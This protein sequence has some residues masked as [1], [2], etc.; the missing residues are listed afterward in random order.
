MGNSFSLMA[1]LTPPPP[2]PDDTALRPLR[3]HIHSAWNLLT[4]D[5]CDALTAA[6]DAK[7][8]HEENETPWPL[9]LS[10]REDMAT[11]EERLRGC[12]SPAAFRRVSLRFLPADWR[13]VTEHGLLYLPGKYVVPGGR[14]NEMHG[15]DS[16]FIA[17]GLLLSG[18]LDLARSI[19]DQ[20]LYQV[21]HYG[22]ILNANRTYFLTRSQPP[23]LGRT[24]LAVYRAGGGDLDWLK[25]ALPLVEKYYF[26]WNVPPHQVPSIGLSRY[27]DLGEGP[28]PEVLASEKDSLGRSHYE[29]VCEYFATRPP[30]EASLYVTEDCATLTDEA[31]RSDRSMRESGFDPC[32]RFGPFNLDCLSYIPICLNT[33]LWRMEMDIAAIRKITGAT[34]TRG[35]W[36]DRA[37]Q[38]QEMIDRF[39]WDERRGIYTDFHTGRNERSDYVFATTFW[40]LWAGLASPEQARAVAANLPVFEAPGGLLSGPAETGCQWDAP[41]TWAPLMNLAVQGLH[42]YGYRKDAERVATRFVRMVFDEFTRTG[43]LYEKYDAVRRSAEVDGLL[44]YGY[45]TNETGFGW[46]NAAVLE[47]LNYLGRSVL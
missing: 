22:T 8:E 12:L 14:F 34:V 18:R 39:L 35:V 25:N 26:Y 46:T 44:R 21:E 33:L 40:P 30:E 11:V 27:C 41:F 42:R 45:P 17:I 38:R 2:L 6:R 32:F 3:D 28:A 19:V 9:Y 29:R 10:V 24:V 36:L 4:R 13:G 43:H 47:L 31:W 23:L 16:H 37:K 7:I 5:L 15:W 20:Q 1:L